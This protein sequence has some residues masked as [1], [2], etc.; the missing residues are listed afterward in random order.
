MQQFSEKYHDQ[1]MG[2]VTGFDRLVFR[3]SLRR[4]HYGWWE[5]QREAIVAIGREQYLWHN[6]IRFQDYQQPVKR[7]SERWKKESLKPFEKQGLPVVFRR[8]ASV[9]KEEWARR[10]AGDRGL[11]RGLVCA[12]ST[13][14][15]S[16][17]FE[18]RGTPILRRDRPWHVLY[19][20][21]IHPQLG[22]M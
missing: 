12:L 17:T 1:S 21:Q 13:L 22:W 20:Y 14:E 4:L 7:A 19:P 2:V 16:P 18:H 10:V 5:D 6:K 3:G 15:P 8:S 9:D 11:Q